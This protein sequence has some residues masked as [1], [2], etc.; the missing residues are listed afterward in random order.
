MSLVHTQM[1]FLYKLFVYRGLNSKQSTHVIQVSN[2]ESNPWVAKCSRTGLMTPNDT[3][4]IV[5]SVTNCICL[6]QILIVT[7][8]YSV[9]GTKYKPSIILSFL[10]K[11]NGH[12]RLTML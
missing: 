10:V 2:E 11:K 9:T 5:Y 7:R 4:N 12:Y 1:F 3:L 6:A 8:P